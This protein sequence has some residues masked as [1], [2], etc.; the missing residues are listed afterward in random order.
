[1]KLIWLAMLFALSGFFSSANTILDVMG[2]YEECNTMCRIE[3]DNQTHRDIC[4][5]S[6]YRGCTWEPER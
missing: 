1:M 4:Q 2:C 3:Y 6:C 5:T